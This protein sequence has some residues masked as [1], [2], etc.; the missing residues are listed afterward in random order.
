[1]K[2]LLSIAVSLAL[3]A[4]LAACGS[5]AS[6][7]VKPTDGYAEGALGDT[8]RTRFFDYKVNSAYLCDE[9]EGYTPADGSE[10]LVAEVTLTNTFGDDIEMYDTDFQAQWGADDDE[11]AFSLPITCGPEGEYLDPVHEDQLPAVYTLADKES[12]TGLLVYEVPAGNSSFSISYL[13]Y[14]D[15][16]TTGD[17]FFVFFDAAPKTAQA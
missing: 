7:A 3:A 11:D 16:D 14:F 9:F 12:T 5:S 8:M 6:S 15:D 1:M 17:T 13:E 2:K 4:T 10:L